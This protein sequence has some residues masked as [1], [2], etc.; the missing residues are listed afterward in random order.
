MEKFAFMLH[1]LSLEDMQMVS[2]FI[3]YVPDFLLEYI[4]Q[5]KK[6]LIIYTATQSPMMSASVISKMPT[7][8]AGFEV[9]R[10][11]RFYL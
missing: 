10:L 8:P 9:N 4:L 6:P 11:I 1:P 3:R 5:K 2:P 7:N